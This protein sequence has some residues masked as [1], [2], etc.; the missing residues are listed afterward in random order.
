MLFAG[1]GLLTLAGSA[2]AEKVSLNYLTD[3]VRIA[4]IRQAPE[5]TT[6]SPMTWISLHGGAMFGPRFG[7]L[8]GIDASIPGLNMG[9]GFHSRIDADVI[10]KANFAGI[11]TVVPVTFD[12][13]WYSPNAASGHNMYLGAGVGAVLSGPIT[14]DVKLIA[15][16][17]LTNKLGAEVNVHLTGHDTLWTAFVRLHM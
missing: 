4:A 3:S 9:N 1:V 5:A 16:T 13:L 7:G 14:Y 15:G 11:D 2:G 10:F 17:E 8:V 12:Q 6:T